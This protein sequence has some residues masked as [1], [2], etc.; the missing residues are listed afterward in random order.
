MK[1]RTRARKVNSD[2]KAQTVINITS[3]EQA[4]ELLAILANVQVSGSMSQVA[5]TVAL[6]EPIVGQLMVILNQ[7]NGD[8]AVVLDH[9]KNS[10]ENGANG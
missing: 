5:Q 1:T 4:R 8:P 6:I 7:L 3:P 2:Q 9:E 10:K